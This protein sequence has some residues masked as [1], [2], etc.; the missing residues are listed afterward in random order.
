MQQARREDLHDQRRLLSRRLIGCPFDQ[1]H[2]FLQ[3]K[4]RKDAEGRQRQHSVLVPASSSGG[5]TDESPSST[6]SP[7]DADCRIHLPPNK[8]WSHRKKRYPSTRLSATTICPV[9]D[10]V[11]FK[12]RSSPLRAVKGTCSERQRVCASVIARRAAAM[13]CASIGRRNLL[14]ACGDEPRS[15]DARL[16]MATKSVIAVPALI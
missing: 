1:S 4:C 15:D 3:D 13:P 8:L 5:D 12:I 14:A 6:P 10:A 7:S 16:Q 2:G 9:V 11:E